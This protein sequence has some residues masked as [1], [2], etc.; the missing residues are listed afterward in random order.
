MCVCAV[1]VYAY[2][3]ADL[4]CIHVCWRH[5]F[6][7]VS[8][9]VCVCVAT[10]DRLLLWLAVKAVLTGESVASSFSQF[11]R[12]QWC[13]REQ[14]GHMMILSGW[15][16]CSTGKI[17]FWKVEKLQSTPKNIYFVRQSFLTFKSYFV[18]REIL[19]DRW[20]CVFNFITWIY[21]KFAPTISTSCCNTALSLST[22]QAGWYR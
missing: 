11:I 19:D 4:N 5:E 13:A 8:L 15:R 17:Y 18:E 3:C 1:S 16:V 21:H 20:V 6:F 14:A 12:A 7:C 10:S 9:L 22:G 2:V